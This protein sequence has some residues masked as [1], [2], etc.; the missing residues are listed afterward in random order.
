MTKNNMF[1]LN[2]SSVEDNALI[3]KDVNETQLWHL[4]YGH[5]NINGLKLFT[6]KNMVVGLPEMGHLDLCKGC[7]F[8]KQENH[9]L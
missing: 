8:G 5:L 7:I 6:R 4:R 3:P 9:F 1:P 2:V